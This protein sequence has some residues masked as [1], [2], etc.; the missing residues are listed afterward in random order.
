MRRRLTEYTEREKRLLV[1]NA[2]NSDE[3]LD[4][5]GLK[6]LYYAAR[7]VECYG[8]A[9]RDNTFDQLVAIGKRIE[10]GEDGG[11]S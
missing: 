1:W 3:V 4:R 10:R 9:C 2:D 5:T 7:A 8:S 11:E 6:T